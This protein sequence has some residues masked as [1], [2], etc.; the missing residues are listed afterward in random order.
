[1]DSHDLILP[2][3]TQ[4]MTLILEGGC[5]GDSDLDINA[6]IIFIEANNLFL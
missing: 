6:T 3:M 5:D 1:M 2:Q 4:N